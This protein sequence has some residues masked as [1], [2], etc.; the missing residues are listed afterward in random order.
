MAIKDYEREYNEAHENNPDDIFVDTISNRSFDKL[1]AYLEDEIALFDGGYNHELY[2]TR[3]R[4]RI[5]HFL[6][7]V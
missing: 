1:V 3:I 4:A 6:E 2:N 7:T 5:N